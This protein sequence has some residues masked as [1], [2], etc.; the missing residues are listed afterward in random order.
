MLKIT[1]R[2]STLI[3]IL[4]VSG[5]FL[6]CAP[7]CRQTRLVRSEN[8]SSRNAYRPAS[9]GSLSS[10]IRTVLR[11]SA[12]KG[13]QVEQQLRQAQEQDPDLARQ[14]EESSAQPAD[15][16]AGLRLA[17]SYVKAG[18]YLPAYEVYQRLRA[19]AEPRADIEL[20]LARIWDKWEDYPLARTHAEY[21]LEIDAQSLAA[22]NLLG[23]IH[24]HRGD[25]QAAAVSFE[26]ALSLQQSDPVLFANAGYAY[27]RAGRLDQAQGCLEKALALDGSIVE[28]HNHLGIVLA[29]R[30]QYDSALSHFMQTS[31]PA[32][33]FNNLGVVCVEQGQ[34][35]EA[36]KFL[37]EALSLKPGYEQALLHLRAAE[38]LAPPP[39]RVSIDG[40]AMQPA[41]RQATDVAREDQPTPSPVRV[42]IS[43][44]PALSVARPEPAKAQIQELA[45]TAEIL[46]GKG[47]YLI[48][49]PAG[50]PPLTS[51]AVSENRFYYQPTS[52]RLRSIAE[53]LVV[54][55]FPRQAPSRHS[56][57]V[58]PAPSRSG[59][60]LSVAA[61]RW[62]EPLLNPVA[63][64]RTSFDWSTSPHSDQP[65]PFYVPSLVDVLLTGFLALGL[66]LGLLLAGG[67][68][69]VLSIAAAI[70]AIA[71]R[72]LAA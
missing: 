8:P 65:S 25:H 11:I 19:A 16:D 6:L 47:P 55:A 36:R 48:E 15:V 62:Q 10:Y 53:H 29:R 17:A 60:N 43:I 57:P 35:E 12:E 7:N 44:T 3:K 34:W 64:A 26:K 72:V 38:A 58:A 51:R 28:A 54:E 70:L 52:P 4:T 37:R 27:L 40:T 49:A 67:A 71:G 13:P 45:E 14:A 5:V 42:S 30:G 2:R 50:D 20:G 66:L 59:A 24:L 31:E 56:M 23:R 63:P 61:L 69:A 39:A 22:W 1:V 18:L 68:G 46:L 33:A 9:P 41:E 32:V 21:A